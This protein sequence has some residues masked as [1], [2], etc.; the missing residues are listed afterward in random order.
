MIF[1]LQRLWAPPLPSRAYEELKM[2]FGMRRCTVPVD[3]SA[4]E[5]KMGEVDDYL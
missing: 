3:I 1:I 5:G 2:R 4:F